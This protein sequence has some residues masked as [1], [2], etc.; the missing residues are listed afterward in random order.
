MKNFLKILILL[1]TTLL[2]TSA[3][4]AQAKLP[5]R[6]DYVLKNNERI[7]IYDKGVIYAKR[8]D[9]IRVAGVGTAGDK[10]TTTI[11]GKE[12]SNTVDFFGDWFLLFSVTDFKEDSTVI[13]IY[14]STTD[15]QNIA[16]L[17]LNIGDEPIFNLNS[18]TS[19]KIPTFVLILI[20][21]FIISTVVYIFRDK[22]IKIFKKSKTEKKD[23]LYKE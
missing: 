17:T 15:S 6:V 21:V 4:Y 5:F 8:G 14:S 20:G 22:I 13:P 19:K 9:A 1:I 11:Y 23:E 16:N 3:I 2:S 7:Q 18:I 10:I 12:Y